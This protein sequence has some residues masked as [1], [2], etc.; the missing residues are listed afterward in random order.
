LS[1]EQTAQLVGCSSHRA[2]AVGYQ[3]T[4]V[5]RR[6][7]EFPQQHPNLTVAGA[8]VLDASAVDAVV[9]SA[10]AILSTLAT[11]ENVPSMARLIMREALS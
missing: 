8:D 2:L 7:D 1:S 4:A 11:S 3:V 5:T 9:S 6:P 10:D